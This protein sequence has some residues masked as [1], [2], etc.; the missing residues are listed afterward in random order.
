MSVPH[1]T[2]PPSPIPL[3]LHAL[4][5]EFADHGRL[6]STASFGLD[7]QWDLDAAL[8]HGWQRSSLQPGPAQ[9]LERDARLPHR[10]G[11][12][13]LTLK[14]FYLRG[15]YLAASLAPW[16]R[17]LPLATVLRWRARRRPALRIEWFEFGGADQGAVLLGGRVGVHFLRRGRRYFVESVES[18][19]AGA[20]AAADDPDLP[21]GGRGA[22][23]ASPDGAVRRLARWR[24]LAAQDRYPRA[25]AQALRE[26]ARHLPQR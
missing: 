25:A 17:T 4:L 21:G 22:L 24:A 23:A 8:A 3:S 7:P 14:P 2:A 15:A 10:G 16:P 6:L 20:A 12:Q 19:E 26:I 13:A 5:A 18:V 11:W 9:Q 1:S